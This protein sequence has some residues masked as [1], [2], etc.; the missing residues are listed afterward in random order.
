MKRPNP[1]ARSFSTSKTRL[2][3]SSSLAQALRRVRNRLGARAALRAASASALVT[4]SILVVPTALS[5]WWQW[6]PP[7]ISNPAPWLLAACLTPCALAA[8]AGL[9]VTASA[10]PLAAQLFDDHYN[11]EGAARS[12]LA[13]AHKPSEQRSAFEQACL[14]RAQAQVKEL[15][16]YPVVPLHKSF[17][18]T[19]AVYALLLG[20]SAGTYGFSKATVPAPKH[21]AEHQGQG[22]ASTRHWAKRQSAAAEV[23][24]I[25]AAIDSQHSGSRPL[26]DELKRLAREIAEGKR[27]EAEVLAALRRLELHAKSVQGL[28]AAQ[29]SN[30]I[31][32]L[33]KQR[34]TQALGE[35]M[36]E[37]DLQALQQAAKE[38][39][40]Q[41]SK[42]LSQQRAKL[43][44]QL[45]RL[46]AEL[47]Q[48]T[49]QREERL[50][51]RPKAK[52][53]AKSRRD[54]QADEPLE[55]LR[56]RIERAQAA[57]QA[58]KNADAQ[59][60]MNDALRQ[61]ES[62]AR[63]QRDREEALRAARKLEQL[64]QELLRAPQTP[65]AGN[66]HG[67]RQTAAVQSG[68]Q[69][70]QHLQNN[71]SRD[72]QSA[73][74]GEGVRL[75]PQNAEGGEHSQTPGN[76]LLSREANAAAPSANGPVSQVQGQRGAGM[77]RRQ[78][79]ATAASAGFSTMGYQKVHAEYEEYELRA[80]EDAELSGSDRFA[81]QR[82]FQL[83]RPPQ[84]AP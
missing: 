55:Q 21:Q 9:L 57:L 70:T 17:W 34:W 3:T 50:L 65:E 75:R 79:I 12:A 61:L 35:A 71:S 47:Q 10:E 69:R 83:I 8:A 46:H 31:E 43:L 40:E 4:G 81:I 72:Q 1:T 33:S 6:I 22:A 44:R 32:A 28:D 56:R 82:Y 16:A 39:R 23:S 49:R 52:T 18:K 48:K 41:L 67:S 13:F 2:K 45:S 26:A 14:L 51:H 24:R 64:R 63:K 30:L 7:G 77:S 15:K 74:Q 42:T 37:G 80:A 78:V 60:A 53:P 29:W 59:A 84:G 36:K 5:V 62:L 19:L 66:G 76:P 68:N 25:A 54:S 58:N 73:E 20:A 27:T 38:R 11:L